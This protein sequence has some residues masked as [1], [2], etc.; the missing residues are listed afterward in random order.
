MGALFGRVRLST[1]GD[2]RPP[3]IFCLGGGDNPED[4]LVGDYGSFSAGESAAARAARAVE[5]PL[6][7]QMWAEGPH[8]PCIL[9]NEGLVLSGLSEQNRSKLELAAQSSAAHRLALAKNKL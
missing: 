3:N 4:S 7:D 1:H 5:I 2:L 8:L 9:W 6:S